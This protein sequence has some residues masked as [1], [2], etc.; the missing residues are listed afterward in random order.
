[1]ALL[2]SAAPSSSFGDRSTGSSLRALCNGWQEDSESPV[3]WLP[4]LPLAPLRYEDGEV[5][6][7]LSRSLLVEDG[8]EGR[9]EVFLA[10]SA[11]AAA[12]ADIETASGLLRDQE[13]GG[14]R[15]VLGFQ[16]EAGGLTASPCLRIS[17]GQVVRVRIRPLWVSLTSTATG[18]ERVRLFT[19]AGLGP[20]PGIDPPLEAARSVKPDAQILA[21]EVVFDGEAEADFLSSALPALSQRALSCYGKALVKR[22]ALAGRVVV[23]ADVDRDGRV[24]D[25][26]IE[27]NA[28]SEPALSRCLMEAVQSIHPGHPRRS[29]HLSV[30]ISLRLLPK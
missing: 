10:A 16:A 7:R 11:I 19:E 6:L 9:V 25:P 22:P 4:L 18:R 14:L 21:K 23:G 8:P 30:P 3:L 24:T 1:M 26:R 28:T 29:G 15:A 20:G 27:I 12:T 5:R 13:A 17:G 2:S